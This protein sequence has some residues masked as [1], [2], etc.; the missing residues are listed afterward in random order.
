MKRIL[1]YC[2]YL[3]GMGH[4]VRSTEI[5]RSLAQ[6]FQVCFVNGGQTVSRFNFP[7]RVEVVPLPA[8]REEAGE[9]L[10]LDPSLSLEDLKIQRQERLL[11]TFDRF[12]P[13]CMVTECFPFSKYKMAFEL[14][15]LLERSQA[16][17]N[18]VKVI[19]SLRDLIMTQ[20]ASPRSRAKKQE[21]ICQLINQYYDMILFHG[22]PKVHSLADSFPRV[23]DLN[24]ELY[25]TGYVAQSWT[26]VS[27]PQSQDLPALA[28]YILASVGGG[29]HGYALLKSIAVTSPIL[30]RELPHH[31]YAFAGPFMP[32]ADYEALEELVVRSRNITLRRYTP[33]LLNYMH[34]ADLSISLGG[35]NTTMNI[36]RTKVRALILPS[37]G[38]QQTDEQRIRARKLEE[39]GAITQLSLQDLQ[40]SLLA[41]K[42]FMTLDQAPDTQSFNLQ[43]AQNASFRLFQLLCQDHV[44][45]APCSI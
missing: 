42:I 16:S 40:P 35:Y 2:Q 9:L 43:G 13:D 26:K 4:L 22:D 28:P 19:C 8:I 20:P 25:S 5:V 15:P 29:R 23:K 30:E 45:A 7:N 12:A 14:I 37:P 17:A 3:A 10:P 32:Q 39:L 44:A 21:K 6:S 24:C 34:H 11:K 38:S 1:F 18:P 31:I 36:L 41:Q 33:H 27:E